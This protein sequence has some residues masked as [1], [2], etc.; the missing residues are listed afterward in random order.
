MKALKAW[1]EWV[2]DKGSVWRLWASDIFDTLKLG[3]LWTGKGT[4]V[5]PLLENCASGVCTD[6][7]CVDCSLSPA[8]KE[9]ALLVDQQRHEQSKCCSLC[10]ARGVLLLGGQIPVCRVC[11]DQATALGLFAP[12]KCHGV[13]GQG[14]PSSSCRNGHDTLCTACAC[15]VACEGVGG[16]GCAGSGLRTGHATLCVNCA[17]AKPCEGV[18]DNACVGSGLRDGPPRRCRA[19]ACTVRCEGL[20]GKG[21]VAISFRN[22]NGHD[23]LCKPCNAAK[24]GKPAPTRPPAAKEH[25]RKH[26]TAPSRPPAAI[27]KRSLGY[28]CKQCGLPKRGHACMKKK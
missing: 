13:G 11:S 22:A 5:P 10:M 15:T 16:Q 3:D 6:G 20:D 2:I 28:M 27:G 8:E 12:H 24:K 21:C 17:K 7:T 4:W 1:K 26:P 23:L 19:C 18:G 25:K 14:C 9:A